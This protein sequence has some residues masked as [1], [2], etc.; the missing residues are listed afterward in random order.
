VEAEE[1]R[2]L[3]EE[4]SGEAGCVLHY[5]DAAARAGY[6]PMHVSTLSHTRAHASREHARGH[7]PILRISRTGPAAATFFCACR[8]EQ[9]AHRMTRERTPTP[10]REEE[11]HRKRGELWEMSTGR[12]WRAGERSMCAA[13]LRPWSSR[14]LHGHTFVER[15]QVPASRRGVWRVHLQWGRRR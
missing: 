5:D 10:A 2:G 14:R 9:R 13:D 11:A 15:W 8:H 6:A 4:E 7:V 1:A 12:G 3:G